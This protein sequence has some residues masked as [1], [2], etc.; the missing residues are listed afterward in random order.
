MAPS[1]YS[2]ALR[3]LLSP[4]TSD[5]WVQC[6]SCEIWRR[7]PK[8]IADALGDDEQWFCNLNPYDYFNRCDAPQEIE[9]DEIDVVLQAQA[10]AEEYKLAAV[11]RAAA[12]KAEKAAAAAAAAAREHVS[13]NMSV[14]DGNQTRRQFQARSIH[15]SPYDRVGVV[16]ADP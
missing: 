7:V 8:R 4:L 2:D 15:W 6:D 10:A 16:N 1:T 12:E 5:Q 3:A 9:D 11:E 14:T 13:Y